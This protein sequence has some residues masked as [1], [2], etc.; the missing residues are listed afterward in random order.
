MA[1][2]LNFHEAMEA[3]LES[4]HK[5][6]ENLRAE[7][8]VL[9]RAVAVL[10]L[11]R[12]ELSKFR[13]LKPLVYFTTARV[14]ETDKLNNTTMYLMGDAKLWWRTQNADEVS[15]G[16]SKIDTWDKLMKE[17]RD[18]FLPSNTSWLARDKFKR[19]RQT[20]LVREYITESTSVILDIQNMSDEDKLHNFIS[21]MQGW[22]QNELRRQNVKDFARGQ[23]LLLIC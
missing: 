11:N 22:A 7:I 14:P 21:G 16:R 13:N 3:Q 4:L 6:N 9:C 5:D 8:I 18:Q 1:E 19:L 15:A 17:M 2:T 20:G 23:L 10:S 12:G